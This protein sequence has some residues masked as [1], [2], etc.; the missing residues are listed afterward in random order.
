MK[1]NR[2]QRFHSEE[3]FV[4]V[5]SDA[6]S[7]YEEKPWQQKAHNSFM[8]LLQ[9]LITASRPPPRLFQIELN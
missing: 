3:A 5:A 6:C 2:R 1:V 9:H 7:D 8:S 4:C